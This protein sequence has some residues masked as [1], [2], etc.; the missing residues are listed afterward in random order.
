ME[1]FK[2]TKFKALAVFQILFLAIFSAF[3]LPTK[4][5]AAVSYYPW[6]FTQYEYGFLRS[7][8]LF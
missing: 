4:V 8:C 7:L 5:E 6:E 2:L 1:F 3:V